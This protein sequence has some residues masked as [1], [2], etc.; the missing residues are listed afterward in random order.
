MNLARNVLLKEVNGLLFCFWISIIVRNE[1]DW[2]GIGVSPARYWLIFFADWLL[3]LVVGFFLFNGNLE[4]FACL[5]ILCESFCEGFVRFWFIFGSKA[6]GEIDQS[7]SKIYAFSPDIFDEINE[8]F[9]LVIGFWRSLRPL[10]VLW[11]D[12]SSGHLRKDSNIYK[13]QFGMYK[14]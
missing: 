7:I 3:N 12:V 14:F 1:W 13:V 8:R 10:E 6:A 11:K 9:G 5:L 2:V 4:V